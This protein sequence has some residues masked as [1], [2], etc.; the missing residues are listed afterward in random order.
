MESNAL[1]D[2]EDIPKRWITLHVDKLIEEGWKPRIKRRGKIQ[3]LTIRLGNDERSLGHATKERITLF[4]DLFPKFKNSLVWQADEDDGSGK[5][6]PRILATRIAKP[7][8]LGSTVHLNLR[9]LQ[10][11]TYCQSLGYPGDL[12]AFLNSVVEEYFEKYHNLELA[13]V[14]GKG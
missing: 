3:Y 14:I 6:G 12:D 5:G 1:K 7:K 11:Y 4:T 9:T 10:W 13:V 8:P 2:T